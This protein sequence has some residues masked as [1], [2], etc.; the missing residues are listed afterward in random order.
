[1]AGLTF[2]QYCNEQC[3]LKNMHFCFYKYRSVNLIHEQK[4][5]CTG[6]QS[7]VSLLVPRINKAIEV[8]MNYTK[9]VFSNWKQFGKNKIYEE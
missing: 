4:N 3:L 6:K 9:M 7:A 5:S 1:M 8:K 2:L